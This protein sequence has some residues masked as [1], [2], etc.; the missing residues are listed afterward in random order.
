[1]NWSEIPSLSALRAFEAAARNG[2]FSAAARELNVT[3][4]AIA[5]RVRGLEDTF[6]QQLLTRQGRGMA[7]TPQ[8]AVFAAGL[9]QGFSSIADSVDE[10]RAYSDERPLNISLTPTIAANWLIHRL[11]GFWEQHPDITVNLTPSHELVSLAHDGFDMAIRF[12]AGTWPGVTSERLAVGRFVVVASPNL[13]PAKSAVC[14]AD[15]ADKLW[16]MEPYMKERHALLLA[17]GVDLTQVKVT[18]FETN[19]MVLAA[20]QAGMGVSVQ[21]FA[22]VEA[23]L[24]A[25]TLVNLC[26]IKDKDVGYYVVTR[27]G[28]E[29]QSL[30]TFKKWLLRAAKSG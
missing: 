1:M 14:V 9:A 8:G 3:H 16:L 6:S 10:L 19:E 27:Q 2:S 11:G 29:T 18:N 15:L 22:I 4:A 20:T 21:P 13:I 28:R 23:A 26:D 17:E 7:L 5:Q 30:L 25:G 12:G 24:D